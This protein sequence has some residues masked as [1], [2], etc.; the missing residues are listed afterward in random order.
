MYWG[1]A[2]MAQMNAI[3]ALPVHNN[4]LKTSNTVRV[5]AIAALHLQN[6]SLKA[7]LNAELQGTLTSTAKPCSTGLQ[8][9]L[10]EA[11]ALS[12]AIQKQCGTPKDYAEML[13]ELAENAE[14][15]RGVESVD[16]DIDLA[17]RELFED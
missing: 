15:Q 4:A 16:G 13:A 5:N 14:S 2:S 12:A 3:A 9:V 11:I 8:K 6:D 7:V 10:D 17:M 1:K